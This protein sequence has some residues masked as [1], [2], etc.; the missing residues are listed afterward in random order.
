MKISKQLFTLILLFGITL[1]IGA[2]EWDLYDWEVSLEEAQAEAQREDKELF[3]YFAGSDWCGWCMRFKEE[4]LSKEMFLSF[5]SNYVV[6]VILDFPRERELSEQMQRRNRELREEFQVE[7]FPTV[8]ILSPDGEE[9]FRTGYRRGGV[10]AYVDHL[11][12]HVR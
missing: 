2:Q 11:L 4:I 10:G 5:A 9:K 7:G 1:T 8:V 3:Y 12:P 6:P